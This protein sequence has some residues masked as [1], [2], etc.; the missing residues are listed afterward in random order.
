MS[1]NFKLHGNINVDIIKEKL[2][3]LNWNEYEFRQKTYSVHSKTKTIPLMW[4]EQKTN[5]NYWP[6]YELFKSNISEIELLLNTIIGIGLIETAILI[7]LPK[8]QKI[9]SHFDTGDYF[10]KRNRIHIPIITNE[11]C[12]FKIDGE[13]KNMKE[14]EVWEINNNEKEHSVEN[15]GNEDRIHLLIDFLPIL[16]NTPKKIT[17]I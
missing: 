11:E 5:I 15:N 6:T 12:F 4:D 3:G 2:I 17:L 16:N 7:N 1:F 9:D 14:G 8:N 10:L 13:I